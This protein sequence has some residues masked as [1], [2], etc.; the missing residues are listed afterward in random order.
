LITEG[1]DDELDVIAGS[2][3]HIIEDGVGIAATSRKGKDEP[4]LTEGRD[5][6]RKR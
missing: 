3:V 5:K 4:L 2:D 6:K 1:R